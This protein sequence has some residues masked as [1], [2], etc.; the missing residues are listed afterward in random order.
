VK[1]AILIFSLSFAT[2]LPS[3]AHP[4]CGFEEAAPTVSRIEFKSSG[5]PTSLIE[6]SD[7]SGMK[8]VT[9]LRIEL[10]RTRGVLQVRSIR[11]GFVDREIP[12]AEV[13]PAERLNAA[14]GRIVL[15]RLLSDPDFIQRFGIPNGINVTSG[16]RSLV[17]HATPDGV[18][19]RQVSDPIHVVV[20]DKQTLAVKRAYRYELPPLP[21]ID[22]I[23]DIC[24]IIDGYVSSTEDPPASADELAR[25][26]EELSRQ[27]PNFNL[28]LRRQRR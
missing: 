2:A 9:I 15:D 6:I 27:I 5:E 14:S 12:L 11:I 21:E 13:D 20:M 3:A 1:S 19:Y 8:P 26:N 23:F 17:T 28:Y 18:Y 24:G 10:D 7:T 4:P 22:G 25:Q 16:H